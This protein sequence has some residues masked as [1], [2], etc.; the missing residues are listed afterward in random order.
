MAG[1]RRELWWEVGTVS[2]SFN[3]LDITE[4][5]DGEES[6]MFVYQDLQRI[7]FMRN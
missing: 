4:Q 2:V 7:I 3:K 1:E 6:W 5:E